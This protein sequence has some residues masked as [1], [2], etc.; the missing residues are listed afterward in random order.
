MNNQQDREAFEA[1]ASE[2]YNLSRFDEREPNGN[3]S[4]FALQALWDGWQMSTV[5]HQAQ[6]AAQAE[7]IERLK[8]ALHRISNDCTARKA[9]MIARNALAI[10]PNTEGETNAK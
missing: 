2:H 10:Q 9:V 4:L 8:G 3:Y 5:H 6:L 7:E 1:V